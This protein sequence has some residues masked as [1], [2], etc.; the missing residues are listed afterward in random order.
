MAETFSTA[1]TRLSIELQDSSRELFAECEGALNDLTE[2]TA[3][4]EQPYQ[5][6]AAPQWEPGRISSLQSL[7][8]TPSD[9]LLGEVLRRHRGVQPQRRALSAFQQY[10][11][12][13]DDT[14]AETPR[15]VR[16]SGH[17]LIKALRDSKSVSRWRA[18]WLRRDKKTRR[19]PMRSVVG[20]VHRFRREQLFGRVGLFLLKLAQLEDALT[21]PWD[22]TLEEGLRQLDGSG[23]DPKEFDHDRKRWI[24][25]GVRRRGEAI[26]ALT[27]LKQ[28]LDALL[29]ALAADLARSR[30]KAASAR[31]GTTDPSSACIS[32]WEQQ[33]NAVHARHDLTAAVASVGGE[34][35]RTTEKTLL[36]VD[37]ERSELVKEL[38]HFI[39]ALDQWDG[40]IDPRFVPAPRINLVSADH[41][42]RDWAAEARQLAQAGLP[43]EAE[44]IEPRKALPPHRPPWRAVRARDIFIKAIERSANRSDLRGLIEA[45]E[46]H[47]RIVSDIEHA[48]QV[49]L[50]GFEVATRDQ[51]RDMAVEAVA[52]ALQL[53]R[54]RR[55]RVGNSRVVAE[56][57]LTT[58]A[59]AALANTHGTIREG[60]LGLLKGLARQRSR[61]VV[62]QL[63]QRCVSGSRQLARLCWSTLRGAY[64][65]GLIYIGWEPPPQSRLAPLE[66][67][68]QLESSSTTEGAPSLP[69]I[70]ARLFRPES[71][72][73]PR[74]LVGR[75]TEMAAI[76]EGRDCWEAGRPTAMLLVGERG[77]GK[78]SLLNCAR[79]QALAGLPLRVGAFSERVFQAG[80]M[81]DFLRKLF[82]IGPHEDLIATLNQRGGAVILE[83]VERS[84]LRR[85]GG[86][87]GLKRLLT[88]VTR[89]NQNVLW[90]L[91]VNYAAAK[92]AQ[93]A[94]G[95]DRDFSHRINARA[96]SHKTLQQAV[97]QRHHL[98]G[99]KLEF[100]RMPRNA[101][102]ERAQ[103]FLGIQRSA[104]DQYFEALYAQSNGVFRSAF[105]LW[106][107]SIVSA[108]SGSLRL[109]PP[110]SPETGSLTAALS[111]DDM[112]ALQ[113]IFQHGSLTSAE[114]ALIF[115][116]SLDSSAD[117]LKRLQ[118][119]GLIE[120]QPNVP[121]L[122]IRPRIAHLARRVL[123]AHNLY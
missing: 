90:L 54:R 16:V 17:D 68:A 65:R 35:S 109:R 26:K 50:Y 62:Q 100:E 21:D 53:A 3:S 37:K 94:V 119:I 75:E 88:V 66:R 76:Q 113:A 72:E 10:L 81:D 30:P 73:D 20:G 11:R 93:A 92:L 120:P 118:D 38:D 6:A 1:W 39:E 116:A 114:L 28:G 23:P 64:K 85:I 46:A 9:T 29:P 117:R 44:L 79:V 34:L 59:A 2:L 104:R 82:E 69:L 15:V 106:N 58:A 41:R 56:P 5:T 99:L 101:K 43:I 110:V 14:V 22:G 112:F 67:R 45:K 7:F 89:T 103:F 70:Y 55:G 32:Y 107:A 78:T 48:R 71:V 121:G 57:N 63:A 25:L 36:G 13:L 83:E 52:N 87:E 97:L 60:H 47:R 27:A 98:S 74:F 122:R 77:S 105:R 115:D 102:W 108:D 49:V 18:A 61:R 96:V 31:S 19:L 84:Y 24:R 91:S 8:G 80:D 33:S 95:L 42:I 40:T 111:L 4:I 123:D 12:D 51:Q 86:F